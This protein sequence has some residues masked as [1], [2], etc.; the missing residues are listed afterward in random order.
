MGVSPEV[1]PWRRMPRETD[2]LTPFAIKAAKPGATDRKL[3]DGGGLYLRI[4][5]SN[6]RY[7]HLKYRFGGVEKLLAIGP[8]PEVSIA[9]ARKERDAARALLRDGIDPGAQ[10]KA[11]KEAQQRDARGAFPVIAGEWL[12]FKRSGWATETHRKAE[13][14]LDKYLTPALRH[15]SIGTLATK[16]VTKVLE[17]IA[18]DAPNLASKARQYLSGIVDYAI[19]QGL[20]E[21]GKLLSLRGVV[22]KYEKGHIPA[23]V[24]VADISPVVKA[25]DAYPS[26]MTRSALKLTMWTALRPG[27]VASARWDEI[28]LE[29]GEWHIG[30]NR[31]KSKHDHIAPLPRQAVEMLRELHALTGAGTFVFPSPAQQRTPHVNRDSLSAALRRMGFRG[32]HS[33]HGFRGTLRT[34]GRE[35]LGFDVDVLEAQ[36]AHAKKGDVQKAYDRT[37]FDEP[38]REAMQKWA[39]YLDAL[40]SEAK[41]IPMTRATS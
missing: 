29:A 23:A 2:K 27:V 25:I 34:I 12:A 4:K 7:W 3:S 20:R 18:Q 9:E 8:Y 41:V 5:P 10:R 28:D 32:K 16:D 22:P 26:L 11:T 37:T 13:Y 17:S 30:A 1:E 36:L 35:R 39:D 40:K 33:T 19:K 6:A 24:K 38:R 31:M 14:V 21:D 15:R